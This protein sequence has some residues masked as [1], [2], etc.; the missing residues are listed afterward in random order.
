MEKMEHESEQKVTCDTIISLLLGLR[1]HW[2]AAVAW[3]DVGPEVAA[4][5]S[6]N[7]LS[8]STLSPRIS[9][10]LQVLPDKVFWEVCSYFWA[11]INSG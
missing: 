4:S 8:G 5:S 3:D 9:E 7:T 2:L 11:K 6:G 10:Q 1:T